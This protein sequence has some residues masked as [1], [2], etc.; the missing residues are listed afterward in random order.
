MT[1]VEIRQRNSETRK[2]TEVIN[3]PTGEQAEQ[4]DELVGHLVVSGGYDIVNI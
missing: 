1:S 4:S 2:R 3:N